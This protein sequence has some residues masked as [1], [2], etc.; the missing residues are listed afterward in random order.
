MTRLSI[1]E[2]GWRPAGHRPGDGTTRVTVGDTAVELRWPR[3]VVAEPE[4][5]AHIAAWRTIPGGPLT[6]APGD[7]AGLRAGYH[8]AD[9][10]DSAWYSAS[11]VN[12]VTFGFPT[13]E[14]ESYA[15]YLWYRTRTARPAAGGP[16]AVTLGS[17]LE[18]RRLT[19][20]VFADGV[21]ATAGPLTG[22]VVT[23][24]LPPG[25]EG[26]VTI[27]VQLR[28]EPVF[29]PDRARER[30]GWRGVD[31]YC[32]QH[33]HVAGAF[34]TLGAVDARPDGDGLVLTY[35]DGLT[36]TVRYESTADL[37]R[38]RVTLRGDGQWVS[39]VLL[40]EQAAPGA[41]YHPDG[42]WA[43]WGRHFQAAVHPSAVTYAGEAG[44]VSAYWP[45]RRLTPDT[46]LAAPDVVA[47]AGPTGDGAANVRDLLTR[48]GRERTPYRIYD[49]Y[50]W[51]QISH[52]NEPKIE[53]TD[54][55]MGD[56]DSLLDRL[57]GAGVTFDALSLD[58]GWNDPDD[59][60]RFHPANFADGP[61]S[62][63][64]VVKRHDLDLILWVSPSDGARAFRHELGMADPRLEAARA[65]NAAF[66]WRLCPAA[67]PWR[68][69]FREALLRHVTGNGATGFKVDGTELWCANTAHDHAPGIHSLAA[70]TDAMVETFEAVVAAGAPFLMLYWGLRSPWWLRYGATLWER[71]YLV[72]AAGPSGVPS[73][74]LRLAVASSQDIG[75]QSCW[76][77]IPAHQQ[78]SLGVWVST[79][80]WAS[81]QGAAQWEDA[82]VLDV[83][84]G[85]LLNQLWG[86]LRMAGE[87]R[88]AALF[89]LERAR[90]PELLGG[91]R[92][93]GRAWHDDAYGYLWSGETGSWVVLSRPGPTGTVEVEVPAGR[94]SVR[95]D[96]VTEGA[97]ARATLDG[98]VLRVA[99]S[100]G[101]VVAV[102]LS[103]E[104]GAATAG[105]E[106]LVP[107]AYSWRAVGETR[108]AAGDGVKAAYLGRAPQ[109]A[110]WMKGEKP[111]E[112]TL[113]RILPCVPAADRGLG[114]VERRW[115]GEVE[116]AGDLRCALVTS[117]TRE[118]AAWHNDRLH[119]LVTVALEVDGA[120]VTPERWPYFHHEQAGSWSST[121]DT[122]ALAA[123]RHTVRATVRSL[124]PETVDAVTG[125]WVR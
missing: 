79:T 118:G 10:D 92:P 30:E 77:T 85:S 61:A 46:P 8:A 109:I 23:V 37:V 81:R 123:G 108:E 50:G 116:A 2:L 51:Y 57:A 48:I 39:H 7:E 114:V 63:R 68:T 22:G 62:V 106:P 119:E 94:R 96:Y 125:L 78:D 111:D 3:P 82:Q 42:A 88:I 71:D 67:D 117:V 73:W 93:V 13:W 95:I 35:P 120:P 59:L 64:S 90:Q 26:E 121:V 75:Q 91:G 100:G 69:G 16:L 87:S 9:L 101:S 112:L 103:T 99:Q 28:V 25:G 107:S 60:G 80:I 24:D 102:H 115:E 29:A 12:E 122:F 89:A 44:P 104:D 53:L 76:S 43:L 45:G 84:R 110:T 58:C 49:P 38:Q 124:L 18:R 41:G 36:A 21:E 47:G 83:A 5:L 105:E 70:T 66:P 1:E 6:E 31:K 40:A 74:N 4:R 19:W 20:R 56:I 113:E 98:G 52:V 65:A 55:L 34:R 97:A 72:E 33:V 27:A 86:D 11:R 54:E 14:G 32:Y 17:P 15:G